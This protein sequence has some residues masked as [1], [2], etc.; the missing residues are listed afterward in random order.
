MAEIAHTQFFLMILTLSMV[1]TSPS[2]P[3]IYK[4]LYTVMCCPHPLNS[5][6]NLLLNDVHKCCERHVYTFRGGRRCKD[7]AKLGWKAGLELFTEWTK[8]MGGHISE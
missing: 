5:M 1:P 8:A 3:P 4:L 6:P 2:M 7:Y